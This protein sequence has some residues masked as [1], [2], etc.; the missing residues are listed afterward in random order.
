MSRVGVPG[1]R[2]IGAGLLKPLLD[3]LVVAGFVP[4]G[5]AGVADQVRGSRSATSRSRRSR[6][7]ATN[8]AARHSASEAAGRMMSHCLPEEM[9]GW[10]AAVGVDGAAIARDCRTAGIALA[11]MGVVLDGVR[12]KHRLRGR[13]SAFSVL[14]R[15]AACGRSLNE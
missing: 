13:E 9:R 6:R 11:A 5:V 12:V 14:A 2:G 3:L 4:G 8:A 1:E 10:I 7:C 15:A